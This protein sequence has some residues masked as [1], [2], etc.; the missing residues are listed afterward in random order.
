VNFAASINVVLDEDEF[1]TPSFNNARHAS[2]DAVFSA[3]NA[4]KRRNA[5]PERAGRRQ[6]A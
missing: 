4:T 1:F 2:F 3:I 5:K 6:S